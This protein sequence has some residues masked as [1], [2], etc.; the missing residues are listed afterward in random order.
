VPERLSAQDASFLHLETPTTPMHV[1]SVMLFEAPPLLDA[2]GR[3]RLDDVRRL[4]ESRL[5]AVPRGRQRVMQVPLGSGLPVWVDDD[6]FDLSYH[7]RLTALPRPGTEA[8]LLAL[9]GRLLASRLDRRRPL[10]ELWFVEGVQGDRV[11]L[12][13]KTHHAMVAG[14]SRGDVATVLFDA[15]RSAR[16]DADAVVPWDPAPSP[17]P[18]ALLAGTLFDRARQTTEVIGNLRAVTE[19]VA[20]LGA[21][22][23][24]GRALRAVGSQE[25]PRVPFNGP[26]S[27]GR[28]VE[29]ARVDLDAVR[30][31]KRAYDCTVNDVVLAMVSA[32]L[33]GY[34]E[35]ESDLDVDGLV[36][37]VLIP[38]SVRPENGEEVAA[39]VADL[40]LGEGDTVA[41]LRTITASLRRLKAEGALSVRAITGL[42]RFAPPT[43]LSLAARLVP[44][45]RAVN[46]VVTNVPGPSTPRYCMG[47]RLLEAFPYLGLAGHLGLAVAVV[48]YDSLLHVGLTA[49]PELVP[50][51][52]MLAESLEKA[53]G[54]L[55]AEGGVADG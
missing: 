19:P 8:Q 30:V 10:W 21:A 6:R 12:V 47:A 41:V 32:G 28:R 22:R 50:N 9:A 20:A 15:E 25:A 27:P 2:T 36:L 16:P 43:L 34:L 42:L 23:E 13:H 7:V 18:A 51:L 1:G 40:P 38:V 24:V 52:G 33:R 17:S 5:P 44:L 31:V 46:L 35:G 3:F 55:L 49:D 14:I 48:S 26:L 39:F 45:Q 4:V 11:A 37:K 29:V 53:A 54:D